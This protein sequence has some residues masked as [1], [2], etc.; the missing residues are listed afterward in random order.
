MTD[1]GPR[2]EDSPLTSPG[3]PMSSGSSAGSGSP[4][5]GSPVGSLTPSFSA[6][7][8][9][10]ADRGTPEIRA[11]SR[12]QEDSG[13][14]GGSASSWLAVTVLVLGFAI[15]GIGLCAGPDWFVFWVGAAICGMGGILLLTFRVFR[16]VVLDSPRAPYAS[17]EE[18]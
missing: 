9:F 12:S 17:R 6:A 10:P 18:H 13:N 15:G 11:D 4:S 1:D 2:T 8:G 3:F 16:D 7:P 5:S 14:H